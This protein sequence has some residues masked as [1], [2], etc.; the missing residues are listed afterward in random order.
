MRR[1]AGTDLVVRGPGGRGPGVHHEIQGREL[2]LAVTKRL[3]GE[4]FDAVAANGVASSFDADGQSESRASGGVGPRDHH[5]Q[6]VR[7]PLTFTVNGVELWLVG[8]SA[9]AGKAERGERNGGA[10]P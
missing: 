4:A 1:E 9:L 5:E 6:R 7:R 3:A 8:E 2:L 10:L